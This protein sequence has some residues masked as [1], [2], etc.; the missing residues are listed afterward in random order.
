MAKTR[1]FNVNDNVKSELKFKPNMD[2]DKGLNRATLVSVEVLESEIKEETKWQFSGM[3]VPRIVYRF[4]SLDLPHRFFNK[5]YKVLSNEYTEKY[6]DEIE[7]S[8]Q[9]TMFD[10]FVDMHK[11]FS[12]CPNYKPLDQKVATILNNQKEEA[13]TEELVKLYKSLFTT[14]AKAF[15]EGNNGKPI[16]EDK[17]GNGI[18][19]WL[20]LVSDYKSGL[21]YD[22]PRFIREGFIEV[23]QR[24]N[25]GI[26][27]EPLIEIKIAQGESVTLREKNTATTV[28]V[29]TDD[30]SPANIDEIKNRMK[31]NK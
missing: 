10:H 29:E 9:Q 21:F 17:D 15:N 1:K 3:T 20:K 25:D 28:K 11:A 6:T 4:R 31:R 19:I 24:D 5:E 16:F 14:M 27:I 30:D 12:E 23:I 13:T 18:E 2:I 26:I 8:L 22:V 7:F